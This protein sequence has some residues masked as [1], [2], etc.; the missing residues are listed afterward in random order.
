MLSHD[1][2]SLRSGWDVFDPD[3]TR[4]GTIADTS[5]NYFVIEDDFVRA[6][7][8]FVPKSAVIAVSDGRVQLKFTRAELERAI[9]PPTDDER[10]NGGSDT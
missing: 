2:T 8:L 5:N 9:R 3:G 7:D 10:S 4:I 1:A 6:A